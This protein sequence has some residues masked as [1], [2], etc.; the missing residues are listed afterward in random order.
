[1][2]VY[3]GTPIGGDRAGVT[4]FLRG[5]HALIPY[6]RPEDCEVAFQVC[7]SVIF[8]NGAFS[9]WKKSQTPTDWGEYY[10][11]C[12][13]WHRHPAFDWAIIPD[14]IDGTE[15]ENDELI[16][17]WC[18]RCNEFYRRGVPVWHL[19]ESFDRLFRL[20]KMWDRICLG[21]SGEYPEP[22]AT[23]WMRRMRDAMEVVCDSDGRPI[24]R[25]HGLR[26]AA[27]EYTGRYPFASVDSTNVAQNA[28]LIPRFGT[29]PAPQR[30][31]RAES[32]AHIMED[33]QSVA[34]FDRNTMYA[35]AEHGA[36]YLFACEP[37]HTPGFAE[38]QEKEVS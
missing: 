23:R 24:T 1:M 36:Q 17:E 14:V 21:S 2:I 25:L 38:Y 34:Q 16:G 31:Q 33:Q 30:W 37:K 7:K 28:S 26:M 9:L 15:Q 20:A 4:R 18:G 3:H 27:K 5:R 22:G 8:D 11:W 10:E 6:P 12:D 13:T 29:Y 19:H 32:I 35:G